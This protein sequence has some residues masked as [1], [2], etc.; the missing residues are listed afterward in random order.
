MH[1]LPQ[2]T[3]FQWGCEAGDTGDRCPIRERSGFLPI[4][5]HVPASIATLLPEPPL[6]RTAGPA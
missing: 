3:L 6:G 4:A 2:A 1:T 5:H